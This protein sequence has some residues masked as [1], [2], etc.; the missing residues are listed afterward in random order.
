MGMTRPL[1]WFPGVCIVVAALSLGPSFAHVLEAVPRLTVWPPELWRQATVFHAQ[2][3]WFAVAG[4]TFDTSV[5]PLLA[6][7]A[8][9][10]R[11]ERYSFRL[12]VAATFFYAAALATWFAWVGPANAILA[13]W[14]PGPVPADFF[15]VRDR[16]ETGHMVVAGLKFLGFLVL[17]AATLNA[18]RSRP[19]TADR[20][21]ADQS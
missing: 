1:A 3:E 6:I 8:F 19:G 20:A 5:I 13:T 7:L 2:F 21:R 12:A 15:A 10:L 18:G 11:R 17:I 4:A 9:L 16:W 14:K